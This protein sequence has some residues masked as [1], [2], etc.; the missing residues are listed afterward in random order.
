MK[1]TSYSAQL[2][3]VP[4]II[5]LHCSDSTPLIALLKSEIYGKPYRLYGCNIIENNLYQLTLCLRT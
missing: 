3:P 5:S 2:L 1:P 4:E